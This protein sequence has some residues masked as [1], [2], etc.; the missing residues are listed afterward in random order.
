MRTIMRTL[1]LVLLLLVLADTSRAASMNELFR[2]VN[3]SVGVIKTVQKELTMGKE[4][5][6]SLYGLG[7]GVLISDDGKM[8]TA[9]HEVH[10]ADAVAVEFSTGESIPA[11]VL[12]SM[13]SADIALLQ[14]DKMPER[15]APV[16]L[17]DSDQ[18][19]P[20][21]EVMVIGA[22]YGL[23]H[24]LTAGHISGRHATK[25]AINEL[26]VVEILQSDA[27]VNLGNSGGPMFNM[28][29]E[30]IGI[31]SHILSQSGGFEGISFAVAIN[32]AKRMLLEQPTRWSGVD[33]LL[34]RGPLAKV[35]NL[36][37][38]AGYLVQRVAEGSGGE[39]LGLRM[40]SMQ[41]EIENRPVIVGGDIIL[42][43]NGI[44]VTEDPKSMVDIIK[45]IR[46][47]RPGDKMT[48]K[49][50][51]EGQIVTLERTID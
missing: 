20:G 8:L 32:V 4:E 7:S 44:Q 34:I 42:E 3:D 45:E 21:D 47:K 40:G 29:G 33:G 18:M 10:T 37:Q 12:G 27:A 9:A 11:K 39:A 13:P 38:K 25:D 2:R 6:Q 22:P 31:V 50:L 49:V 17:G 46:I 19:Q 15:I 48:V 28:Q 35:F 26:V 41:I 24:T 36:P 43:M 1:W 5:Q 14:L 30:V 23:S 16:P 51:R